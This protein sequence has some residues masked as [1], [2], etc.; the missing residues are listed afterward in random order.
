MR[1]RKHSLVLLGA[2]ASLALALQTSPALAADSSGD[3]TVAGNTIN[4]SALIQTLLIKATIKDDDGIASSYMTCVNSAQKTVFVLDFH[5]VAGNAVL[6]T[7]VQPTTVAELAARSLK[8]DLQSFRNGANGGRYDVYDFF[9]VTLPWKW[10]RTEACQVTLTVTDRL[11]N[12]T[13]L[14]KGSINLV[15]LVPPIRTATPTPAPTKVPSATP[16]P[17]I[18]ST[19]SATPFRATTPV[20]SAAP[21]K[22]ITAATSSPTPSQAATWVTAVVPGAFCARSLAGKQGR[23]ATGTLYTCKSSAF[24]N[25]LRWRL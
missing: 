23:S 19:P 1:N 11:G 24:E 3:I 9:T 4:S 16:S 21:S 8:L 7:E 25:I 15:S 18:A 2:L 14:Q 13:K 17:V 20:P 12:Q 6:T 22:A 5:P 10:L